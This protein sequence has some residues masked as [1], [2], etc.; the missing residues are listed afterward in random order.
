VFENRV[1]WLIFGSKM[2]EVKG[3]WKRLYNE[4][5][6]DLYSPT[7]IMEETVQ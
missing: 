5:P 2:V 6:H 3:D 7:N 4:E 1:V